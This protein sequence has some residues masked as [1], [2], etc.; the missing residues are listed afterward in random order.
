MAVAKRRKDGAVIG[1]APVNAPMT[2][3]DFDRLFHDVSNWGRWGAADERGT[4]N[5][6]TP[7]TVKRSAL[8]VRSGRSVSM[9]RPIDTAAAVD[10]PNPAIHHMT[11]SYDIPAGEG[12]PQFVADYLG[13][14]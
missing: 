4:L 6:I 10:N 9:S 12:E 2:R 13:C 3:A 11:R 7:E 5:Y 14:G 8:L 1:D